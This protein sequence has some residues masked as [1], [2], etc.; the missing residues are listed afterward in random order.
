MLLGIG[1]PTVKEDILCLVSSCQGS[2]QEIY[3]NRSSL[4]A[5]HEPALSGNGPPV[6]LVAGAENLFIIVRGQKGIVDGQECTPIRPSKSQQPEALLEAH[7][8]MVKHPGG[9]FRTLEAGALI[10]RV[11]NDKA[12][13]TIL[14]GQIAEMPVDNPRRKERGKAKPV[15]ARAHEETIVGVL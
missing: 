10:Q 8:N 1:K 3:H 6:N 11:V 15:G 7:G 2:L 4:L 9:K 14:G 5:G 12:V 13:I